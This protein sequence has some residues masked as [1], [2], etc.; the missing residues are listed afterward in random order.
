MRRRRRPLGGNV[1]VADYDNDRIQYFTASGSYLG[2]WGSHG[3]GNGQF[4]Y[5]YGVAVAPGGDVY[6]ADSDNNRVQYFTASGSYL[7]QWG[8]YGSGN[9][10]FNTRADC[11]LTLPVRAFTSPILITTAS[12]TSTA[13]NRRWR[14]LPSAG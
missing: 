12:N 9:G 6:V 1:Y 10:Q 2:Q 4:D 5:P 13:T 14:R 11:V 7:G 8:T 3:S